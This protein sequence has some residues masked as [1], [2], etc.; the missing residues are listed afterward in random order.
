MKGALDEL[1]DRVR[2]KPEAV[3]QQFVEE[4]F[5]STAHLPWIPN[6]GG[7]Q[8]DAYFSE[9]DEILYGG[10]AGGGKSHLELGWGINEARN[11]II[12]RR[13]LAQTDGLEAEGKKI[14]G[15]QA[16][17]N[18]T[19]HEWTWQ[20][21][22]TLKLG[23]MKNADSWI[24]HAGRERDYFAF[25]EAGEF[26]EV[27]VASIIGGWL[28]SEPGR[29]TRV[30]FGS[31]PPRSSDGLWL[32]EW[33]A[34]WLDKHHRLYPTEPGKLIWCFYARGKTIWVEGPGEYDHEGETYIA[35]SRTFIPASLEDNPFR[36]NAKY[37]GQLMS[38]PEPLRSQLL[39][40]DFEA[41]LEDQANQI[42]PTAWVRAA[43][44]RAHDQI[45]PPQD[46]PMCAI[47]V[48][49]SGGGKDP[50]VMA[51]RHDGWFADLVKVEGKDIPK[52]RPGSHCAGLVVA[53]RRDQAL[54]TVDLG[55]GYG[56]PMYEHMKANDIDVYGFKGA[57]GTT[58]K[59][60][61]AKLKFTN[62]RTAAYWMVREGLDP[63]QPGGPKITRLPQDTRLL[64]GLTA[65]TFEVTPHGIKAEP[66][67]IRDAKGK[68]TGGVM[69][70]LGFSPDESDAVVMSWFEGA[71][72]TTAALDW[73]E[74]KVT[75]RKRG[76]QG[77]QPQVLLSSRRR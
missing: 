45:E 34:P 7:P 67:V 2:V 43:M 11:G 60:R 51:P 49:A 25:D 62:K 18:G 57:E 73:L 1:L 74:A 70:K 5:R 14:I 76:M 35:K 3:R 8:T 42:I 15:R 29:R 71:R 20:D 28:R 68:I 39:Y 77:Q 4:A 27:Q 36:N 65:A 64:A 47:G 50:M 59:S 33:F 46:V 53:R 26:L 13:E 48:D 58:K 72:E 23:G 37:R 31:N 32:I 55:G 52:D 12:F 10:R 56:G 30:I 17:F 16:S 38:L 40:G 61:D 66:K 22:K 19:D 44:N 21:G 69:G 41:G 9:A 6:P 24:D 75:R 63:D 54:I